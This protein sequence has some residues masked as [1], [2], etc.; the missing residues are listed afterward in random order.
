L[1]I[2]TQQRPARN[3][4]IMPFVLEDL[5]CIPLRDIGELMN[6]Q[7][8]SLNVPNQKLAWEDQKMKAKRLV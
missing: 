5:I 2:L 7:K 1:K 6:L 3:A 8:I 4:W